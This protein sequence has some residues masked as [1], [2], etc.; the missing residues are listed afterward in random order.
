MPLQP[1]KST[2]T[3]SKNISE[4]H[5][6]PTFKHT[7]EKFGKSRAN[8]QAVAVAFS[9]ARRTGK[10][11]DDAHE[12]KEVE[13]LDKM[14]AMH[15]GV[16]K[17]QS[18]K[19]GTGQVTIQPFGPPYGVAG[20]VRRRQQPPNTGSVF[21][22]PPSGGTG[23]PSWGRG[24]RRGAGGVGNAMS[25][26]PSP[27]ASDDSGGFSTQTKMGGGGGESDRKSSPFGEGQS[28][29]VGKGQARSVGCGHASCKVGKGCSR[30]VGKGQ[31][32]MDPTAM[33]MG[34]G[35]PAQSM[36]MQGPPPVGAGPGMLPPM[37][38]SMDAQLKTIKSRLGAP[39][40]R[41]GKPSPTSRV[42][43]G[44]I[45]GPPLGTRR[46]PARASKGRPSQL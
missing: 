5:G 22:D 8:K 20:G 29:K 40:P 26:A 11:H 16:G 30:K 33:S 1:G 38:P 32:P 41:P 28:K 3:I 23:G 19:V 13:L 4:F 21:G 2:A 12:R 46:A 9:E 27:P 43:G 45:K 35:P 31:G 7:A 34:G 24:G 39:P 42:A 6:G 10:G 36:P 15:K 25:I 37:D 44:K 18:K 14:K 17:G